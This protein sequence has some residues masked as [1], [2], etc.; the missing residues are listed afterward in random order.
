M[1]SAIKEMSAVTYNDKS[2]AQIGWTTQFSKVQN[3]IGLT[4]AATPQSFAQ[5]LAG[6][7]NRQMPRLM[8]DGKLGKTTWGRMK[9]LL[10]TV[11]AIGP[12][13]LWVKM[14][15]SRPPQSDVEP[16]GPL[17]RFAGE[18]TWIGVARNE[19]LRWDATRW[20]MTS[21]QLDE[22]ERHTDM[23]EA[24]F[25]A[26]PRWGNIT[27]DLGEGPGRQNR[28]WCAAFV[29]YCLHRA[30]HSHTG[31]AGAASFAKR[32]SWSFDALEEPRVGCV[33]VLG[34]RPGSHV[35]FLADVRSL[36]ENPRG[37]VAIRDLPSAGV[38][39]LGGNQSKTVCEKRYRRSLLSA[40]G[41]NGVVSP[42]FW[43]L[44]GGSNCNISLPTARAHGCNYIHSA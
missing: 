4:R 13:P 14:P 6:W 11:A 25:V 30:G 41:H 26:S 35:S 21:E 1:L 22:T 12:V 37:D 33:I 2:M 23:D 32:S 24:Y 16:L 7:Q 38:L 36:P 3:L 28:D 40:R 43:P 17:V 44:Q 15:P 9:P 34:E 5:A 29:N 27:H 19:K 31:S 42:Y 8:P 10:V 39:L 18:P 20:G